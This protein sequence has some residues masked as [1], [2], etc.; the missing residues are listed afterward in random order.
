MPKKKT[1][2]TAPVERTPEEKALAEQERQKRLEERAVEA[3]AANLA[4][5]QE[6]YAFL[7]DNSH[8]EDV[9]SEEVLADLKNR[10][11]MFHEGE[12]GSHF[13]QVR[14][15][16]T[17]LGV[18]W[19]A[20]RNLFDVLE[21]SEIDNKPFRYAATRWR[22]LL[23]GDHVLVYRRNGDVELHTVSKVIFNQETNDA[24]VLLADDSTADFHQV[25]HVILD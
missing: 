13:Y 2:E 9:T 23:E 24:F 21:A 16:L 15:G 17:R 5:A 3:A 19:A 7:V 11:G 14:G 6:K 1:T 8:V 10:Y 4:R 18:M 22:D 12:L 25:H 20:D